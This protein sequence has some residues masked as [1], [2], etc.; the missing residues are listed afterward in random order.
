[1]KRYVAFHEIL[2]VKVLNPGLNMFA[3]IRVVLETKEIKEK[4]V[5]QEVRD[6]LVVL[7]IEE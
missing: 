1:M 5:H 4:W 2:H 7:V 6:L 3:C